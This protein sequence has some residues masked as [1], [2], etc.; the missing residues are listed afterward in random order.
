[1]GQKRRLK[2]IKDIKRITCTY[3]ATYGE[4]PTIFDKPTNE[5]ENE[6]NEEI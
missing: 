6:R 5:E 1:M 4:V 3:F 2:D